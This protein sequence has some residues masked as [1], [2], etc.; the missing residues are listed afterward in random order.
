M[1]PLDICLRFIGA[2]RHLPLPTTVAAALVALFA[3]M[4]APAA[5]AQV[6]PAPATFP[7][8]ESQAIPDKTSATGHADSTE[9]A[10]SSTPDAI[11]QISTTIKLRKP[12]DVSIVNSA[13]WTPP[14]AA[15]CPGRVSVSNV[16]NVDGMCGGRLAVVPYSIRTSCIDAVVNRTSQVGTCDSGQ[17]NP[18]KIEVDRRA[19][20]GRC[21]SN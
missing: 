15:P 9:K 16:L 13:Q 12:G 1:T 3:S 21:I 10:N 7:P 4:V 6:I 18:L 14:C 11:A 19:S 8:V 2:Q 5:W 20:I 17:A